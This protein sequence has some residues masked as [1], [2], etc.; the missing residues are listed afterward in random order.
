MFQRVCLKIKRPSDTP[1]RHFLLRHIH[2]T[3]WWYAMI[4]EWNATDMRSCFRVPPAIGSPY[5]QTNFTIGV[6]G[7]YRSLTTT[8]LKQDEILLELTTISRWWFFWVE[9]W[10][11]CC[12]Q[13]VVTPVAQ[14][15]GSS[16][17]PQIFRSIFGEKIPQFEPKIPW[18]SSPWNWK[19]KTMF[20]H[21]VK[22]WHT[23]QG[24]NPSSKSPVYLC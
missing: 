2:M 9:L 11:F 7:G 5:K 13:P 15:N 14:K 3:R 21:Q 19:T 22:L 8:G 20:D 23:L 16:L 17:K 12:C 1:P 4:Q 24:E 6:T 18:W 10:F